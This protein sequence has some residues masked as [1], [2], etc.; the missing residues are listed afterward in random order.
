MKNISLSFLAFLWRW[1]VLQYCR[2]WVAEPGRTKCLISWKEGICHLLEQQQ[3]KLIMFKTLQK[4]ISS[5][6]SQ[7]MHLECLGIKLMP[8]EWKNEHH[9]QQWWAKWFG[10]QQSTTANILTGATPSLWCLEWVCCSIFLLNFDPG[11]SSVVYFV[12]FHLLQF[13]G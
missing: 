7:K 4:T 5:E 3:V 12:I 11:H 1:M 10:W 9:T 8:L 6:K 13:L 2:P